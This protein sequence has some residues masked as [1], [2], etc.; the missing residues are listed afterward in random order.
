VQSSEIKQHADALA[1]LV[2][3]KKSAENNL[4]AAQ[5]SV[6]NAQAHL[7]RINEDLAKAHQALSE[8]LK[9]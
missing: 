9:G 2:D 5:Q 4:A 1:K 7:A 6:V 3:A 8:A